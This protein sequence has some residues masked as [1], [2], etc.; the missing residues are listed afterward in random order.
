MFYH[1]KFYIYKTE[2]DIPLGVDLFGLSNYS[3]PVPINNFINKK[4]F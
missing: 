2:N 4:L 3:F 1:T